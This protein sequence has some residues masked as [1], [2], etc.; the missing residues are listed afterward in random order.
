MLCSSHVS[1]PRVI[2]SKAIEPSLHPINHV[3]VV[4]VGLA[5][6]MHV[7]VVSIGVVLLGWESYHMLYFMYICCWRYS[8]L[9][10]M[11]IIK[12]ELSRGI[13]ESFCLFYDSSLVSPRT[14]K[15]WWTVIRLS[16]L[17]TRGYVFGSPLDIAGIYILVQ[18]PQLVGGVAIWLLVGVE[19]VSYGPIYFGGSRVCLVTPCSACP[20]RRGTFIY[21][22]L[23]LGS[24]CG[25]CSL[26][27]PWSQ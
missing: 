17:T 27:K 1:Y 22:V 24:S 4:W 19:L 25:H 15:Y 18:W 21:Q 12:I 14:P 23:K 2:Q 16:A 13:G 6:R 20:S 11:L 10:L 26:L 5:S 3:L 7:H 8:W 9:T